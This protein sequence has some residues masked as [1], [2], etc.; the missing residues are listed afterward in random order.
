MTAADWD[1]QARNKTKKD[2]LT[3]VFFFGNSSYIQ[4]VSVILELGNHTSRSKLTSKFGHSVTV[5]AGSKYLS[6]TPAQ[7]SILIK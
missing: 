1:Q 7:L 5:Y 2:C 3:A 4:F 6:R